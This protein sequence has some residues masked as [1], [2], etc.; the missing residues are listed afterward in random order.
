MW[1]WCKVK[2][3]VKVKDN[4]YMLLVS[5]LIVAFQLMMSKHK[6]EN[7][8]L[9]YAIMMSQLVNEITLMKGAVTQ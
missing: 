6:K 3:K 9:F 5:T 7:W 1:V 2:A 8:K 4:K